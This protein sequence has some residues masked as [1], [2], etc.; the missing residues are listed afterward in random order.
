MN[1]FLVDCG[2]RQ[3][4]FI[5]RVKIIT[6]GAIGSLNATIPFRLDPPIIKR[7]SLTY[8]TFDKPKSI[9]KGNHQVEFEYGP[10]RGRYY[11]RD[12]DTSTNRVTKTYYIGNVEKVINPDGSEGCS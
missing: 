12:T 6:A 8:Y 7:R 9:I 10:N 1:Q 4:S 2:H 5:Q 11:R 3:R